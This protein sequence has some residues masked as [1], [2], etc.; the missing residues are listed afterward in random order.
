[1]HLA[2]P[3]GC[4][5]TL[6][7]LL[8]KSGVQYTIDDKRV[9]GRK[10][11]AKFWGELRDD[12]KKAAKELLASEMGILVA[13]P[14]FGKTV[15]AAYCI[16]K[17]KVNTLVIVDRKQLLQQWKERLSSFLELPPSSIGEV[18]DG[19]KK[20]TGRIDIAMVKSLIKDEWSTISLHSMDK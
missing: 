18:S 9:A 8:D 17:R 6:S 16:S 3:R 15:L 1:M 20:P 11:R 10:I 13:V 4:L 7:D 12:Q 2:L 14:G 5:D 19:K